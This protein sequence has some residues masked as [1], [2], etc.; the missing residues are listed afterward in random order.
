MAIAHF[1]THP[2]VVVDP[3]VP[4]PDWPLSEL[5][6]SRAAALCR[7]DR[8]GGVDEVYVS[9]ERKALDT[10]EILK[11]R[12]GLPYT[13]AT[14]LEENDRSATGYLPASEFEMVADAF[15]AH[16]SESIRGWER[17]VDAQDRI[18][19]TVEELLA[20]RKGHGDVAIIS[21]GAVG[22]LLLCHLLDQPID[23]KWDQ[24]GAGGGNVFA[25]E[26]A[27]RRLVHRWQSIDA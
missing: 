19:K 21:H 27:S 17:A 9:H 7:S 15:F 4:V 8:L 26:I 1:I 14:G 10:A 20:A 12:L 16:G 18:R 6:K 24:P 11:Q 13:C 25:F 5:G 23:R 3:G 22:A 2:N